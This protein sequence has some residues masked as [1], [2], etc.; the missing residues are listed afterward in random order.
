M[1]VTIES[2]ARLG[3]AGQVEAIVSLTEENAIPVIPALDDVLGL[4][5][6]PKPCG[7]CHLFLFSWA[8]TDNLSGDFPAVYFFSI[9][10]D[11]IEKS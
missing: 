2:L 1:Q 5:W 4:S 11:P 7:S 6:E 3:H 8:R 10:S 9:D